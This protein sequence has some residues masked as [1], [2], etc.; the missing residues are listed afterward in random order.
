M[1]FKKHLLLTYAAA[2]FLAACTQEKTITVAEYL[3]NIDA[4]NAAAKLYANDP[5]K[6][7]GNADWANASAALA[8]I[9]FLNDC[10]PKKNSDRFSTANTDHVCLD[11]KGYKR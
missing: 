8:K 6:H 2:T 11:N 7:Q 3:H 9:Q 4:A 10:W 5:A 1:A